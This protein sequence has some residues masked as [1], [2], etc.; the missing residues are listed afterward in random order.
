MKKEA[1]LALPFQLVSIVNYGICMALQ[2]AFD[3]WFSISCC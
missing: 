2:L 1:E 3:S